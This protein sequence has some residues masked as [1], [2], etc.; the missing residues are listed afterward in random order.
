[1]D[2]LLPEG[3]PDVRRSQPVRPAGTTP[4]STG[5]MFTVHQLSPGGSIVYTGADGMVEASVV[6]ERRGDGRERLSCES[7]AGAAVFRLASYDAA[8][9]GF[10]CTAPDDLPLGSYVVQG[11][12]LAVRDGTGAPVATLKARVG[13]RCSLVE[14]GGGIVAQCQRY[15]VRRWSVALI[16]EAFKSLDRRALVALPLVALHLDERAQGPSGPRSW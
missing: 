10:V 13:D 9:V 2:E 6:L 1:M 4:F 3:D 16:D 8:E 5:Q 12:E 11:A 7:V 14:T 15:D